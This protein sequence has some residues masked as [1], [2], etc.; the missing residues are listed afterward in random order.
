MDPAIATILGT[1]IGA[2]L[3]YFLTKKT[4]EKQRFYEAAAAFRSAF[5]DEIIV[6][7]EVFSGEVGERTI[8]DVIASALGKHEKAMILF[9]PHVAKSQLIEFDRSWNEY[10]RQDKWSE[11]NTDPIRSEYGTMMGMNNEQEMRK[12]VLS[13]IEKLLEFAPMK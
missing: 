7:G 1:I 13:R 8:G 10:S 5:V 12:L 11:L 3:G 2:C 4:M 9:R 6:C